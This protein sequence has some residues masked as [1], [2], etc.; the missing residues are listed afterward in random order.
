MKTW[1]PSRRAESQRCEGSHVFIEASSSY[2]ERLAI[3]PDYK[4]S[5]DR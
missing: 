4:A 5:L 1:E 2:D 3:G